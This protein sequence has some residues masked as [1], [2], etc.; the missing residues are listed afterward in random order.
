[1]GAQPQHE[2]PGQPPLQQASQAQ[3]PPQP[4]FLHQQAGQTQGP[5]MT[6]PQ[7][8]R[9]QQLQRGAPSPGGSAA[10]SAARVPQQRLGTLPALG[11]VAV[12]WNCPKSPSLRLLGHALR[13]KRP[14]FISRYV[15]GRV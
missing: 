10:V 14:S 2:G 3:H 13:P 8:G 4:H 9:L 5:P 12:S 7:Q 6:P 1:V 11:I 15:F